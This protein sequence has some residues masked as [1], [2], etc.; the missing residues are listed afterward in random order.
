M[1][2]LGV[3]L[4]QAADY[5]ALAGL[6]VRRPI[7]AAPSD[8]LCDDS[9]SRSA[10]RRMPHDPPPPLPKRLPEEYAGRL[11]ERLPL[12]TPYP[13]VIVRIKQ[14]LA[15][16]EL[17]GAAL[18]VDA[19]GVGRP[20]VDMLR[21]AGLRP[22]P[23]VITGG[24]R[25][26]C[27]EGYY[28]VPKRDLVSAA[29]VLLQDKRLGVAKELPLAGTLVSE[30]LSFRVRITAAANDVYGAWREGQHDDLVLALALACWWATRPQG[31]VARWDGRI[32]P[33]DWRSELSAKR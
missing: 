9:A 17:R 22:L 19:T 23:V 7:E 10:M 4:G 18:V 5:T 24:E 32:G 14:L 15:E 33:R 28:F 8:G 20:V 26:T 16:P 6:E 25:A 29:L 1:F 30:L 11:L 13:A 3:D 12:G 27:Q 21:Q 31:W 2:V